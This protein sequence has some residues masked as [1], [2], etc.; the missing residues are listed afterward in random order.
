MRL[1]PIEPWEGRR[2]RTSV[3]SLPLVLS[4]LWA[5]DRLLAPRPPALATFT[6]G[7]TASAKRSAESTP[8]TQSRLQYS[9]RSTNLGIWTR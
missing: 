4:A 3:R 9:N 1:A 7:Y 2:S 8:D 5:S 6:T